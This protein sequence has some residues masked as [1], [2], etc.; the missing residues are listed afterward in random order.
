MQQLGCQPP[1]SISNAHYYPESRDYVENGQHQS[2]LRQILSGYNFR[3]NGTQRIYRE[4]PSYYES[5][6]QLLN[7]HAGY[8][9][10]ENDLCEYDNNFKIRCGN[11]GSRLFRM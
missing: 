8:T 11:S 9:H 1:V 7:L 10:Q 2:Y 4:S 3:D 6:R 5:P